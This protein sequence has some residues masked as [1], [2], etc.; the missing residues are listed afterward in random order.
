MRIIHLHGRLKKEFGS[1]FN[2][3][4][5]TTGEAIRAMIANF[6]KFSQIMSEGSYRIIRGKRKNGIDL[7]LDDF[8]MTLGS[9]DLHIVPVTAGS[10]SGIGKILIG[11]AIIGAAFFT[12][13]ASLAGSIP[14]LGGASI[15]YSTI[16]GFGLML[17]LTGVSQ[18]LAPT[19]KKPD[20]I[21]KK[22][23]YSFSGPQNVSEQG[24]A[25]P[26]IYGRVIT[27]SLP[28]S[29][30]FDVESIG[31]GGSTVPVNTPFN[32]LFS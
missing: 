22:D 8:S 19:T 25:I 15:S 26:L 20:A 12:G 18:M 24:N 28:I 11:V 32:P 30:G 10:K 6:D 2:L 13:G 9:A 7:S 14:L 23:S 21:D 27:G 1:P 4:V 17:A 3:Q 31:S 29:A 16:A 5:N